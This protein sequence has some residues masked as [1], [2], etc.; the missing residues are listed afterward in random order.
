MM[1]D[2]NLSLFQ[3]ANWECR[4]VNF[5]DSNWRRSRTDEDGKVGYAVMCRLLGPETPL[6]WDDVT[7]SLQRTLGASFTSST[8]GGLYRM[9]GQAVLSRLSQPVDAHICHSRAG[10]SSAATAQ[11]V[12]QPK[13]PEKPYPVQAAAAAE[14]RAKVPG[15]QMPPWPSCWCALCGINLILL[16]QQS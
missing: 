15:W 16:Y 5:F 3:T 1:T 9:I 4:V 13:R 10:G 11:Q 14:E 2:P 7:M 12:P 8:C 6:S